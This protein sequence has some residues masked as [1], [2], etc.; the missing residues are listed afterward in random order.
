[1]GIVNKENRESLQGKKRAPGRSKPG[2]Q[3]QFGNIPLTRF[4]PRPTSVGGATREDG[5]DPA[6]DDPGFD[7][8][9]VGNSAFEMDW[10]PFRQASLSGAIHY[11][12][13]A[14]SVMAVLADRADSA[15]GEPLKDSMPIRFQPK[16]N[17]T[18]YRLGVCV[19]GKLRL[20]SQRESGALSRLHTS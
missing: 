12:Q 2:A 6:I 14:G 17:Q 18:H 7:V 20:Y 1:M 19:S 16:R 15:L 4:N 3:P 13:Q 10:L 5:L 11:Q 9:L 8:N